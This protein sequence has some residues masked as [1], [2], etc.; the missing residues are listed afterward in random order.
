MDE[1][2]KCPHCGKAAIYCSIDGYAAEPGHPTYWCR[3]PD[4]YAIFVVS[5]WQDR[6]LEAA[7]EAENKR[8]KMA[9]QKI[10]DF[11]EKGP[12]YFRT[13]WPEERRV[14]ISTAWQWVRDGI[15]NGQIDGP[16]TLPLKDL[17]LQLESEGLI[18]LARCNPE[19]EILYGK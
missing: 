4:E 15:A 5:L 19:G 14:S 13:I 3:C 11:R 18:T 10:H 1:L 6:P 16:D 17:M 2:K 9:L 7:L 8:L 12:M